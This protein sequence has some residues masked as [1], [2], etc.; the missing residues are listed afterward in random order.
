VDAKA[1]NIDP[2]RMTRQF[3]GAFTAPVCTVLG[4]S[5]QRLNRQNEAVIS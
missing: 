5:C 4:A 2:G 3:P 1:D